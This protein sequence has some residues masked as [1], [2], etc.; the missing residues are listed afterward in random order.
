MAVDAVGELIQTIGKS[1][2]GNREEA[3][4]GMERLAF[5]YE[6]S[7]QLRSELTT[8]DTGLQSTA[9]AATQIQTPPAAQPAESTPAATALTGDIGL[10]HVTD[11][12]TLRSSD[13]RTLYTHLYA[14]YSDGDRAEVREAPQGTGLHPH[15]SLHDERRR[16]WGEDRVQRLPVSRAIQSATPG[17]RR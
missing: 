8:S 4:S 16:L 7:S 3:L 6:L 11:F 5:I 2:D 12:L 14:G 10:N 1:F 13:G 9:P 15:L 17:A